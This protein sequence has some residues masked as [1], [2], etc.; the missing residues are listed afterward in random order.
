[1]KTHQVDSEVI[2]AVGVVSLAIT[3]LLAHS[4]CTV[5]FVNAIFVDLVKSITEVVRDSRQM[6]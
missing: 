6:W 5:L 3:A 4:L 1:M 2:F